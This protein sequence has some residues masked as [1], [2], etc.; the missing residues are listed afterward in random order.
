MP[1]AGMT[2]NTPEK[3]GRRFL[4]GALILAVAGVVVKVI[5]SLN[6]I[7]LSWILGGEGIGIYQIAFP[8]YLLALSIS[9][10][11]IPVAVSIITAERAALR[12]YRGA[13]RVFHLSFLL[14]A[15]TGM[16]LSLLLFFGAGWLIEHRMIRDARAYYSIIA[17]APAIFLVTLLSS[18]RGYLQGWQMM[19]PTAVS[20]IVEQ[21]LRVF[22][23]LVFAYWLLPSGLEFAAGGA[24][25]GAGF[26]AVGALGVLVWYYCRL[27]KQ[28]QQKM[29]LAPILPDGESNR[30]I[31]RRLAALALPVSLSS[32]MLPVVA[33][34]DLFIVPLRLE[35]AGFSVGQATERFGY[36]TG[37]AVPLVNLATIVTASL[38]ISL[39]PAISQAKSLGDKQ[40]VL[41]RTA[42]AMRLA[43]LTTVPFSVL[44]FLLAEPVVS[45][46]YHAPGA[47][48]V[49]QVMA[50]GIFLLG[51][52][53]VTTGLLQGLGRTTIPVVNMGLAAVVKVV[54]N[55]VLTA[56]PALGI[57]GA[58]LATLAD[59]GLAAGLNL[60]FVYRY[61]GYCF[62][63]G[64]LLKNIAAAA[65][66]GVVVQFFYGPA[67]SLLRIPF[68]A[69][70]VVSLVGGFVYIAV[71]LATGGLTRRDLARIPFFGPRLFKDPA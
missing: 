33:N 58:G 44:L 63:C 15:V 69:V 14:L 16:V 48:G 49:T 56:I 29:Q 52:H 3:S 4:K 5:G 1:E 43:N 67:L 71:M 47:A 21:L 32:L 50:G 17:L 60:Y 6:W 62:P 30:S 28:L 24:S 19:A 10:A 26:G 20:Q 9:D 23:M 65:V 68:V 42:G 66:M 57:Q 36:L 37:M 40:E 2:Q 54:L 45:M 35:A 64:D 12:D 51:L 38:S 55:W 34:L 61:T 7:F 31:L 8:L 13:Q 18:F 25:L 27:Q 22:T 11:G 46:I 70:A 41:Y 59:L 39:V 53:Q